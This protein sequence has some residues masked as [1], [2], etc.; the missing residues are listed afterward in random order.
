MGEQTTASST[1]E[2]FSYP[3]LVITVRTVSVKSWGWKSRKVGT[4][5]NDSKIMSIVHSFKMFA[6]GGYVVLRVGRQRC[7]A[8]GQFIQ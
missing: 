5:K 7:R 4:G 3:Q 8:K 6:E 1:P 2:S